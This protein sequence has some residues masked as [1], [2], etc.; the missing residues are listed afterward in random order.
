MKSEVADLR[1]HFEERAAIMEFEGGFTRDEAE[2]L[3]A[4]Y[5]CCLARKLGYSADAL[6]S[7]MDEFSQLIV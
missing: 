6:R 1:E 5:T 7:I 4:E 3:A 2:T